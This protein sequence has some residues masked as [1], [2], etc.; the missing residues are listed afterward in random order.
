[1]TLKI[2]LICFCRFGRIEKKKLVQ[3]GHLKFIAIHKNYPQQNDLL[4]YSETVFTKNYFKFLSEV[5]WVVL[6]TPTHTHFNLITQTILKTNVICQKP[7]SNED[8]EL[9]ELI[10]NILPNSNYKLYIDDVFLHREAYRWL[11]QKVILTEIRK[12]NFVWKKHGS[13]ADNLANSLLYHD[14]LIILDFLKIESIDRMIITKLKKI[15][16]HHWQLQLKLE[17][18]EINFEYNRNQPNSN[19]KIKSMQII[20]KQNEYIWINER[21]FQNNNLVFTEQKDAI[22]TMLTR[23][24]KNMNKIKTNLQL[25]ILANQFINIII[26][27]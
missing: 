21:V 16:Q 9:E 12:I 13:F 6:C 5:D 23:I 15:N 1:M 26:Q 17:N 8:S 2:S 14:I 19:N 20:T 11:Q 10:T 22:I 18:I 7:I 25:S 27:S 3:V 24:T 4:E